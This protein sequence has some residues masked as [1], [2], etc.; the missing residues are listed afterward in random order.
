[1]YCEYHGVC[2]DD[3]GGNCEYCIKEDVRKECE[4]EYAK[5]LEELKK[6]VRAHL[7]GIDA[8]STCGYSEEV[9]RAWM[10]K[11]A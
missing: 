10:D 8:N 6:L 3:G 1:M 11:N 4:E 2:T 7:D 5:P 9:L